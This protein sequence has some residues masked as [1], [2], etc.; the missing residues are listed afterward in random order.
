MSGLF[1]SL[2]ILSCELM[3]SRRNAN[4]LCAPVEGQH[5]GVGAKGELHPLILTRL[6][7]NLKQYVG[8]GKVT[9]DRVDSI[10]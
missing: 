10:W 5:G 9:L 3:R 4:L 6:V 7:Y 8:L 1:L 2:Y